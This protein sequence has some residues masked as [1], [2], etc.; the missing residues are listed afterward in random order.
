MLPRPS[1]ETIADAINMVFSG[2]RVGAYF[3]Q[4]RERG[5]QISG[6]AREGPRFHGDKMEVSGPGER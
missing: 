3:A 2:K 5:N 1:P 6:A 4:S